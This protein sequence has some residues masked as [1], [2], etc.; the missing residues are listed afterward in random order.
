MTNP[1]RC[2]S[3]CRSKLYM[4]HCRYRPNIQTDTATFIMD[5]LLLVFTTDNGGPPSQGA[6]NWPLRG[7]KATLWEGGTRGAGFVYSKTLLKKTGYT[8]PGLFHAVDWYP[9]LMDI[10]GGD[11][12]QLD[13]DGLS[14]VDMI[15]N[16]GG[17]VRKEFVYN[18]YD[19]HYAAALR[20]GDLKLIVGDPGYSGWYPPAGSDLDVPPVMD[21]SPLP[22]V[23]LYNISADPTEHQ[24]ISKDNP[25]LVNFLLQMLAMKNGTR[26]PA[27][28]PPSDPRS[29]P[30]NFNGIW[31]PGWC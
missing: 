25:N 15:L 17:S 12:S 11:S 26:V 5:N 7:G 24:D 8:H 27:M 13:I 31:S 9:T 22:N 28:D 18:I 21:D 6:N 3:T 19:D 16:G 10:A 20:W 14:Q 23:M 29:N 4:N 2:I 30:V 1:S